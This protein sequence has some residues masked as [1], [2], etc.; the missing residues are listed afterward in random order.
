M[1]R[2]LT[3]LLLDLDGVLRLW[4]ADNEARAEQATGL[5]SG[6]IRKIAF[7][8][9][10]LLPAITGRISDEQWRQLVSERLGQ[11]HP[12]V[13]TERAIRLWSESSGHVNEPVR[14]LV[15]ACRRK[16]R[17]AL[18]SNATSRLPADLARLGLLPL[19]DRIINSSE[20]GASKPAARIFAVA[21]EALSAQAADAFFADDSAQNVRAAE[22]LGIV[23][24]LFRSPE[25]LREALQAHGLL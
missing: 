12:A 7:A 22:S 2:V 20:V 8:D 18:V 5:P 15:Q 1:T 24:H 9:D 6:A 16:A 21:L 11:E 14:A 17:V 4:S 13:D 25:G 10:L 19:F 3:S 23:G